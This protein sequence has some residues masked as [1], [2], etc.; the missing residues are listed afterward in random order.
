M[1]VLSVADEVNNDVM[2]ELLS[3][4]GCDLEDLCDIITAIPIDMEDRCIDRFGKISAVLSTSCLLGSSGKT[5]LI[6]NYHMDCTTYTVVGEVLHLHGLV[7][8][9]LASKGSVTMD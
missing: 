9:S 3:I 6:V 2:V 5:N 7:D 4:I 1:A 8:Y